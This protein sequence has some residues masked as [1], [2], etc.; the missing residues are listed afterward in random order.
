MLTEGW[1]GLSVLYVCPIKALLNNLGARL[2][3]YC[4]LLG[5]RS[6]LWHGDVAA[7]R[8][9]AIVRDP[10]DCLLTTP[11]SLE[12]MLVSEKTDARA[13][14]VGLR[15]VIVDEVHAF[16]GDDRGWHLLGVLSRIERLA[17]REFQRIGLS[18]T[19]GNSE[20]LLGWMAGTRKGPRQ[21]CYPP[22]AATA[23]AAEVRLDH[24]GSLHN[25][26]VV[27]SRLHRGE[28]RLTFVDSR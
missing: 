19:V 10:P 8:K 20:E 5:R 9:K 23:T 1:L 3:R 2:G 27:I 12:V 6:A 14:F 25:A 15:A 13:L 11:E 24:V 18:A 17:G 16:A 26:A 21:V 28:K 22:E 7:G 4:T